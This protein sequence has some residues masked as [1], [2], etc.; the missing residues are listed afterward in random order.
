MKKTHLDASG[1]LVV[2]DTELSL[3]WEELL[4]RAARGMGGTLRT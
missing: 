4:T 3:D 1:A 2:A